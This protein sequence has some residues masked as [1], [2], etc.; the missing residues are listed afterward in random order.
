MI[1]H[2]ALL[3]ASLA[4][5]SLTACNKK[6]AEPA[7]DMTSAPAA[8]AL[9]ETGAMQAE[10][11]SQA[12]ANMAAAGDMFEIETSKLAAEKAVSAKVKTFAKQMVSAH[13]ASTEKLT[14]AAAMATP[15][16][17]P[18]PRLSAGQE[19]QLADLKAKAGSAFDE[20]YAKAQVGAHQATLDTLKGYAAGGE[21]AAL[22]KFATDLVPTVTAHLN[23]AKGL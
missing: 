19:A 5:V 21:E 23:M 14:A 13:T 6:E 15:P 1:K 16:I 4:V 7:A 17:T 10:S 18:T 8:D 22:K 9:D 12:F 11:P 3:A 2:S 20:A